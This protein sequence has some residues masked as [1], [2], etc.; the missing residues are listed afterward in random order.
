MSNYNIYDRKTFPSGK[1]IVSP[2]DDAYVAYL[3]QSGSAKVLRE[4]PNGQT[5]I[6]RLQPGDIIGDMALIRKTKHTLAVVADDTVVVVVI[7][8]EHIEKT[9]R[10]SD[11]LV[12]ALLN[13]LIRRLDQMNQKA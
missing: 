3:I 8:P 6:A 2:G 10:D 13:G 5:E 1:R 11:P 9:I 7:P 12:R 4:D